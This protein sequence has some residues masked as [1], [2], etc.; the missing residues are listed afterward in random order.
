MLPI[1]ALNLRSLRIVNG[2]ELEVAEARH[3]TGP[4]RLAAKLRGAAAKP[5][6][7]PLLRVIEGGG[8]P[9][10]ETRRVL[11]SNIFEVEVENSHL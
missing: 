1:G 7:R 8:S 9:G 4:Q 3:H 6:G 5:E 11:R 2:D 10:S